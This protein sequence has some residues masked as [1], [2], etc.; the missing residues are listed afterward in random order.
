M[1]NKAGFGTG[2]GTEVHNNPESHFRKSV[3]EKQETIDRT[4][5]YTDI[6]KLM[7]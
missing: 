5:L 7:L 6:I 2:I 4:R 3:E 1:T